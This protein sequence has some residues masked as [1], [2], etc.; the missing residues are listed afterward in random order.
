MTKYYVDGSKKERNEDI[1]SSL[2]SGN[3]VVLMGSD[4]TNKSTSSFSIWSLMNQHYVVATRMSPDGKYIWIN[5]PESKV[6]EIKYPAQKVLNS[7][8]MGVAG[9]AANGSRLIRHIHA[10][11]SGINKIKDA[12][13]KYAGRG[14]LPGADVAEQC[15]NFL[16]S[17][18]FSDE[19]T[20]GLLGNFQQESGMRPDAL[21]GGKGPAAGLFQME[22]IRRLWIA[23]GIYGQ[24]CRIKG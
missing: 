9:V 4:S 3:R 12:I 14:T 24:I 7:T 16:R 5:D 20:A 13:R 1:S 8:K 21:Q 10:K 18:G 15:W 19:A 6:P 22:K 17:A 11:G 23:L 2:K